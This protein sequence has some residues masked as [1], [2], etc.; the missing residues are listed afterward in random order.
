MLTMIG[1]VPSGQQVCCRSIPTCTSHLMWQCSLKHW[2][3][4]LLPQNHLY[5]HVTVI[6][7]IYVHVVFLCVLC[8]TYHIFYLPPSNLNPAPT[9][10]ATVQNT[11]AFAERTTLGE[12]TV[13]VFASSA[14]LLAY[15]CSTAFTINYCNWQELLNAASRII[16]MPC[17]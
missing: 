13:L 10:R 16:I 8:S 11:T 17:M 14:C 3:V 2:H 4:I 12:S 9:S 1:Y 6:T 7:Y 15:L 5:V